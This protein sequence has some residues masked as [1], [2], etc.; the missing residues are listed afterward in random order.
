MYV[1]CTLPL[2]IYLQGTP[3]PEGPTAIA[4]SSGL[5]ALGLCAQGARS[6][7]IF[8]SFYPWCFT[9]GVDSWTE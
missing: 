4:L 8:S 3:H 5:V 9:Y 2:K 1:L 6:Q 7:G